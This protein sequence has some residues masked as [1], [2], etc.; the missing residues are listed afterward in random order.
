MARS[1]WSVFSRSQRRSSRYAG[2]YDAI[3]RMEATARQQM[4]RAMKQSHGGGH[5]SASHGAYYSYKTGRPKDGLMPDFWADL[6]DAI[7]WWQKRKLW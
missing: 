6:G 1:A 4:R 5:I 3:S 7:K 2:R